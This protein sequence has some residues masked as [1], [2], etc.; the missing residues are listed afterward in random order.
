[1]SERNLTLLLLD[2]KVSIGRIL[3]YTAGTTFNSYEADYKT[4]DAV[5]PNFE[6][7]GEAASRIPDDF[8]KLHPNVEWRIIK[9][10][11][12]FIIHEYFGINNQ[13]VWYTIQFRLPDLLQEILNLISATE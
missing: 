13:I 5:E 4:K 8:K 7:I 10:F 6:I 2:I 1:M 12:N 9:D 11:R 3:E